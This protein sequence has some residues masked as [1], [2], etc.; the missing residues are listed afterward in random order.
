MCLLDIFKRLYHMYLTLHDADRA[1]VNILRAV[2][3]RVCLNK[4]DTAQDYRM[5]AVQDWVENDE[6]LEGIKG[7]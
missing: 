6:S 7:Y 4:R 1:L 3:V 5:I 2:F